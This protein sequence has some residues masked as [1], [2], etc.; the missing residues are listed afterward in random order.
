MRMLITSNP[1]RTAD[2]LPVFV[3][4][5]VRACSPASTV[6]LPAGRPRQKGIRL[7]RMAY[8]P[9][10]QKVGCLSLL[11]LLPSN[12]VTSVSLVQ[13]W[14]DIQKGIEAIGIRWACIGHSRGSYLFGTRDACEVSSFRHI[15][16]PCGRRN[17]G[18]SDLIAAM[19]CKCCVSRERQLPG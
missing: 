6:A 8:Y 7:R 10:R 17:L 5:T 11:L 12:L 4:R 16:C 1:A 18:H 15:L 14:E 3:K 13:G 9:T 19:Q 2:C